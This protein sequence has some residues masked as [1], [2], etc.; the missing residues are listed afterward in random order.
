MKRFLPSVL[1]VVV[2]FVGICIWLYGVRLAQ[3]HPR[4]RVISIAGRVLSDEILTNNFEVTLYA[5]NVWTPSGL[6]TQLRYSTNQ[7][8]TVWSIWK[9]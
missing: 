5:T 3:I 9:K 8:W 1:D 6:V 2:L 4:H 7:L